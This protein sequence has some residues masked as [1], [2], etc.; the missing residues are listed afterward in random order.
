M[1][2]LPYVR[3]SILVRGVLPGVVLVGVPPLAPGAS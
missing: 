2:V 1:R 3:F